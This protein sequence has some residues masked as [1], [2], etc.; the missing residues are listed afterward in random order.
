[1]KVKLINVAEYDLKDDKVTNIPFTTFVN[2]CGNTI[3]EKTE[4]LPKVRLFKS[5]DEFR[6]LTHEELSELD[7][8]KEV[9]VLANGQF[10]VFLEDKKETKTA[11]LQNAAANTEKNQGE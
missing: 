2:L 6:N 11:K 8:N 7:I 10:F 5:M 4:S 1:M 9:K 3:A